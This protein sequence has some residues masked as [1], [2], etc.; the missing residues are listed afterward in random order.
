MVAEGL[1]ENTVRK[2]AASAGEACTAF[3]QAKAKGYTSVYC[4]AKADVVK[5]Q[6]GQ[7]G[8]TGT[9]ADARKLAD[10]E[11]SDLSTEPL[12]SVKVAGSRAVYSRSVSAIQASRAG[13]SC[14]KVVSTTS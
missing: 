3:P 14:S 9:Q 10:W 11:G 4:I 1:P 5:C 8:V 6:F 2:G 13:N 7:L 12:M